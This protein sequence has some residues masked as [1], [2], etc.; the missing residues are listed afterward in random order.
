MSSSRLLA[1]SIDLENRG[2]H[3]LLWSDLEDLYRALVVFTAMQGDAEVHPLLLVP[4]RSCLS[5]FRRLVEA[6][7]SI[8]SA[9]D[10]EETESDS[11][12]PFLVLFLQ[13]A[14]SQVV[15][16]W[17]NGWRRPLSDM[18]GSLLVVRHADWLPLQRSA[19]DLASFVGPRVHDASN[20]ISM[21]PEKGSKQIQALLPTPFMEVLRQLPGRLPQLAEITNWIEGHLLGQAR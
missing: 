10:E 9:D 15:G 7:D 12:S 21:P 4:D 14:S 2:I 13:Q 8:D 1:E 17:L 19:P 6:R 20:M 11:Q 3:V 5:E 16:P 18:P